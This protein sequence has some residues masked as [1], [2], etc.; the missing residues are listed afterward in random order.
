MKNLPHQFNQIDRIVAALAVF[1]R[2]ADTGQDIGNDTVVG[3]ALAQSGVYQFRDKAVSLSENLARE[4]VKPRQSRGTETCAREMR[5]FFGL[6]GLLAPSGS[7]SLSAQ[8]HQIVDARSDATR[9]DL[10]RQALWDM[11][12]ANEVSANVSHPYR[13]L[14][15]LVEAR[16][17]LPGVFLGLCLEAEDDSDEEFERLLSII[18]GEYIDP[19]DAYQALDISPHMARNSIKVLPPLARQLG[20]VVTDQDGG[21]RLPGSRAASGLSSSGAAPHEYSRARSPRHPRPVTASEIARWKPSEGESDEPLLP[22]DPAAVAAAVAQRAERTD[23]HNRL[24]REFAEN[25]ELAGLDLMEYPFD[26]LGLGDGV[27]IL[28]EMK[29]LDGSPED[30]RVRVCACLAQLLYYEAFD[31][32]VSINKATLKKAAVFEGPISTA[33]QNLLE[34]HDC[35]VIWRTPTGGF[36]GTASG[37]ALMRAIGLT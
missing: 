29:T 12:L 5:R 7:S 23:R 4:A 15:R 36:N 20:D 30:E 8:G 10:L 6:L 13:I 35:V 21:H 18:D 28:C 1:G 24:V 27:S 33:H 31:I 2:L 16:P 9:T 17:G 26:C 34:S 19:F 32:P 22:V 25:L 11:A 14:L 3:R 37:L